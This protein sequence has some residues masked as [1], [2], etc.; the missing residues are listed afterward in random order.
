[1]EVL[2][3]LTA[4]I[5]GSYAFLSSLFGEGWAR[6]LFIMTGLSANNIIGA[7]T[8]IWFIEGILN[9]VVIYVFGIQGFFVPVFSGIS[10]LTIAIGIYPLVL[11]LL[12]ISVQ[13]YSN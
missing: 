9:N 8:G 4:I 10:A 6:Y 1:M 2:T 5:G 12:K 7:N 3:A 13:S 11:F